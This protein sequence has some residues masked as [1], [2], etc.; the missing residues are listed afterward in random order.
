ML[1]SQLIGLHSL[2]LLP[3]FQNTIDRQ[4]CFFHSLK[5]EASDF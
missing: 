5:I 1:V 4:W 3:T 2:S